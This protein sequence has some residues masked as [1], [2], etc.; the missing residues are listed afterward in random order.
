MIIEELLA[1]KEA[2][3]KLEKAIKASYLRGYFNTKDLAEIDCAM[4]NYYEIKGKYVNTE[5]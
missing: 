2:Y 1:Y 5:D 4:T 3:A